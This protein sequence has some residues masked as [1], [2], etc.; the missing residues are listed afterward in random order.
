MKH[1]LILIFVMSLFSCNEQKKIKVACVGDSITFGSGLSDIQKDSYP[2]QLGELLGDNWEVGNFGLSGATM[3][4]KGDLPYMESKEFD[5]AKSFA[6]DVVI[7]KLGTNDAKSQN[8]RFN[9]Y[10]VGDYKKM[11]DAFSKFNSE[12]IIFICYPVPAYQ[13]PFD[14]NGSVIENEML[15]KINEIAKDTGVKIIPLFQELSNKQ[16]LFP[17]G[18]HPNKEGARLIADNV[19]AVLKELPKE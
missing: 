1:L 15:P 11:I 17:D 3:L 9:E 8:W 5:H 16:H 13:N 7:I 19:K 14:I 18:V 4:K 12:P 6:P 2:A 10:F